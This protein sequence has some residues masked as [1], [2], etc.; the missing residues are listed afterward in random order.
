MFYKKCPINNYLDFILNFDV[1]TV[2]SMLKD[3]DAYI[4]EIAEDINNL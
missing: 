1:F 4:G 2:Y 3:T